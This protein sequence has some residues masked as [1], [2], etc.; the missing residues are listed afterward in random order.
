MLFLLLATLL[1]TGYF[2][3]D[4]MDKWEAP[5]VA[6]PRKWK[7][8]LAREVRFYSSLD[9]DKKHLFEYKVMEFLANCKITPIETKV[10]DL[11][12]LLIAASA[13]IPIF[14]FPE[15]KY[16][17][18]DEVLLYS[19]SFNDNFETEGEDRR[20]FG[21]VGTGY[22]EGKMILS[23]GALRQGF[24]NESDRRN[25][26]IHEF[27]HLIDK[28]DGVIDGVPSLLLEK[29][30][31]L[32]WFDMVEKKIHEIETD[33]SDIR[34]YGATN[35][36]EFFAVLCEYFFECPKLLERKHPQLYDYLEMIFHQRLSE[37]EF[38]IVDAEIGRNDP[39][40][41]DSGKKFKRCCGDVV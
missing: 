30:Y 29:Q 3:Y 12:R 16:Y 40:P 7:T 33:R 4:S 18:L 24:Q 27:V 1:I 22:M 20:I 8:L 32:P 26:A 13:V 23:R 25:T 37:R 36:A 2:I 28:A 35:R 31:V 19:S 21:M 41:C 6:M 34:P 14:A 39:C 9:I 38:K 17:N 10:H 11:D 15:W 5:E